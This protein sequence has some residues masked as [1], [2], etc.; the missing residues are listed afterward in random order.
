MYEQGQQ[1][2][3]NG[4][5][6]HPT[7][8]SNFRYHQVVKA[9]HLDQAEPFPHTTC[10]ILGFQCE[11]GVFRN[12]GR[13][14]A[15]QAP[16]ALRQQLSSLAFRHAHAHLVDAGNVTC[17]GK[18]LEQAQALLGEKVTSLLAKKA[19][20]I[21]LGGGHETL[22]GHYL[23]V[24]Q[25]IGQ[26]ARLGI[27]NIDAHFDLRSYEEQPSS[28]TMFKQILDSDPNASYCVLG[29]QRYGNIEQ[30]F[31]TADQLGVTY[32]H[33][34]EM[35]ALTMPTIVEQLNDFVAQHD[36]VILTLCM[37]VLNAAFAPGVSAP[38]P[39]GLQPNTVRTII[40]TVLSHRNAL[41]FDLCEV[42]PSLDGDQRTQKLGAYFIN[43]AVMSVSK[44]G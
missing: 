24:R 14:G 26:E 15:K 31:H 23:G 40:N 19:T 18:N 37:D 32:I 22:Y 25:F 3:W 20:P 41:S 7:E 16:N 29:I 44:R 13:V 21:I 42:N 28:G 34:D 27:I 36:F 38:S 35:T 33:E 43:E 39:F 17:E 9:I 5:I 10:G 1:D 11:E 8:K 6:D 30:L 12:Q 2:H 4:R